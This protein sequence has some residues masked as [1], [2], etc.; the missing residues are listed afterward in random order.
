MSRTALAIFAYNRPDN[1]TH[2]LESLKSLERINEVDCIIFSD[3]AR[4][5]SDEVY[6][7]QVRDVI[8]LNSSLFHNVISRKKNFGLKKNIIDGIDKISKLYE[9]FIVIEDDIILSNKGLEFCLKSLEAYSSNYLIGHIN[10]WNYP[11]MNSDRP[12]LTNYLHC[13]GWASWSNRWKPD[14][15]S[16]NKYRNLSV[17]QKIKISK[18]FST[19]HYSHLYG[20]LEGINQTWAIYWLASNILNATKCLS[21][22]YSM[23]RNIGFSSGE[24]TEKYNFPEKNISQKKIIYKLSKGYWQNLISWLYMLIKTPK[25]SLLRT[26]YLVLFK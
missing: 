20:N 24:N 6:V 21:P 3:G 5:D 11:I 23:V 2:V 10:L 9:S 16:M 26:V 1:L 12:Y 8:S 14:T 22:P 13:W 4:E 25:L 19:L 7:E 18:Y 17:Y 15:F